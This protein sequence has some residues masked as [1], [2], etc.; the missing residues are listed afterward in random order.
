MADLKVTATA[1]EEGSEQLKAIVHEF[2]NMK[3]LW[4][5][6]D[7]WG[8]KTL[9]SAM[10]AF[11]DKWWVKRAKLQEHLEDLQSKMEQSVETWNETEAELEKSLE[12]DGG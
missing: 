4:A 12:S 10:N 3:E 2:E 1:L 5:D 6:G 7:V 8:H 9:K 11:D